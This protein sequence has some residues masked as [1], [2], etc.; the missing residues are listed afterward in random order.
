MSKIRTKGIPVEDFKNSR[1]DWVDSF[2]KTT[3][4]HYIQYYTHAGH[5]WSR[6]LRRCS[7]G[8]WTLKPTYTGCTCGF[9]DFQ[10]FTEWCHTQTGY[11]LKDKAGLNWAI[12]K[13]ILLL[14]NKCYS[15][16]LCTF[17]PPYVNGLF[18]NCEK[19]TT[20]PLGVNYR[21]RFGKYVSQINKNGVRTHL[22]HFKTA[23]DAHLAWQKEKIIQI[24]EVIF[25]YSQCSGS[26]EDVIEALYGRINI[27]VNDIQNGQ[28][29]VKL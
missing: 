23:S 26:R 5:I 22:G 24:Q 13:D 20:L 27:L 14:G 11:L 28:E 4:T 15:P 10:D 7:E 29:T 1:G 3:P 9:K 25:E 21:E 18:V 16:D 12:D 2:N 8:Y 19:V 17:V 6:I